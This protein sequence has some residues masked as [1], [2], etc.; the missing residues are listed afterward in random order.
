M[1]TDPMLLKNGNVVRDKNQSGTRCERV[2]SVLLDIVVHERPQLS[3]ANQ[4]TAKDVVSTS[5]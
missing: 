5:W 2:E 3:Q 1:V 4:Y